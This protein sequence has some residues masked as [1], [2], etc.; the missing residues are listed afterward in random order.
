MGRVIVLS[1]LVDAIESEVARRG[2]SF[3]QAAAELGVSP[4]RMSQWR[5]GAR[6]DW[7]PDLQRRVGAFL[8]RSP[9]EVLELSG[10]DVSTDPVDAANLTSA[11]S[12]VPGLRVRARY[13]AR[14]RPW[15]RGAVEL[16]A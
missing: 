3:N 7:T 14:F 12:A 2:T 13:L 11:A 4:Q 8:G 6:V 10:L 1:D 16:A 15:R 9:L 5:R